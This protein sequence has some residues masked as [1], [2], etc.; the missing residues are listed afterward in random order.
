MLRQY[1]PKPLLVPA[2]YLLTTPP[3]P[4]PTISIVTPSFEQGRFLERTLYSVVSQKYPAL[5]YVVQ[6]AAPPT[7]RSTS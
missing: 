7:R 4:A 5:E 2:K 3:E 6:D 1:R